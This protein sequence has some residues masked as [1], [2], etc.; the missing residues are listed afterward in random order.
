[1]SLGKNKQSMYTC[2]D[3]ASIN[4]HRVG[5]YPQNMPQERMVLCSGEGSS[6]A[7]LLR[8][9][10]K[11]ALGDSKTYVSYVMVRIS[12]PGFKRMWV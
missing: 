7:A 5:Q 6:P 3:P 4:I 12:I 8:A 10:L 9:A 1:M 11:S 2:H